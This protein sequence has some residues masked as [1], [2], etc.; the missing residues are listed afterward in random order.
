MHPYPEDFRQVASPE[1]F[2]SGRPS[3][4]NQQVS[5]WSCLIDSDDLK[6]ALLV[7]LITVALCVLPV[8]SLIQDYLPIGMTQIPYAHVT[9][10][11]AFAGALFYVLRCILI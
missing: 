11:A 9:G 7:A 3:P 6:M 10:K 1:G 5:W 4:S 8:D 2:H